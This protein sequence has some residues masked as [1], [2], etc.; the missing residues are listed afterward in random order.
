[1]EPTAPLV[2]TPANPRPP[3]PPSVGSSTARVA[4]FNIENF[5]V[6]TPSAG[7]GADNP[8]EFI[9]QRDKIVAALAGLNA[10]VIALIE[11]E[12]A[13]GNMAAANLAAALTAT[14]GVGAYAAIPDLAT[15]V[16]TDPDIKSG[17][18]YRTSSVTPVGP[19]M[20]DLA[21]AP[22]AYSRDPLTQ[23]FTVN[24]NGGRFILV[25]NHLR[26]KS[27]AG[28][29]G[30]DLDQGDGQ[31]CAN[32]RRRSQAIALVSYLSSLTLIDS[33][34]LM[35][36]DFNSYG[37]EDPLDTLRAGGLIDEVG[38][39]VP[40][41]EQYSFSFDGQ[42]GRLDHVFS[43]SHLSSQI[44]GVAFWHINADEPDIIDY[45]TENKPDD[46]YAPDAYRCADHDPLVIGLNLAAEAVAPTITCPANIS[47]NNDP[48]LCSASVAF[49]VTGTGTPSPTIVC[50]V[51]AA[52]ITSPNTFPVGT[53]TVNCTA[54]NG[55]PPN[56]TC[57]FTVTVLDTQAPT[58]TCPANITV[59]NT[60]GQCSAVVSFSVT[61]TDLCGPATI[62]STPASGSTFPK[63]TTTVTSVA[64]DGSGNTSTCSFTVTVNDTQAPVITCPANV[65]AA[66][67]S[68]QCSA[69]VNFAAPTAT[70]NCSGVGTPVCA[71]ASGSSFPKGT[72]T[73]TCSVS[74]ASSNSASCSFTV[75][76]NDTQPPSITCPANIVT[77]N[78]TGQCSAV[79]SFPAPVVSDNCSGVGTPTCSPSSGST[80]PK[81]TTT[82][83]CSV[84][85]ASG[86]ASN[87]SFTV[88]V[89][90][91]QPPSISCPANITVPCALGQ[92]S[93]LATFSVT[94]TDNCP[95]VTVVA[96]PPSGSSFPKGTTTVTATATDG[97]GNTASCSFTVTVV[98][99]QKP[100]I[101]CPA[102]ITAVVP[103]ATDT[104]ATVS[105]APPVATDNCPGVAVACTPPSGTCF[106]LGITTVTCVATDSSGNTAACSFTVTVFDACLQDDGDPSR[107]VLVN[108]LTGDYRF[109]CGG[110]MYAG[111]G[112]VSSRAGVVTLEHTGSGRRVTIRVDKML[113]VGTASLQA[114]PGSVVCTIRDTNTANNQCACQ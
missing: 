73:V 92:C 7:R 103:G 104:C 27:C 21:A 58:I 68:G 9:R 61:A 39:Y 35:V 79:V 5:F 84:A 71:P 65:T 6:T 85:D 106:P 2:F 100:S 86:N 94:A 74:D 11:L 63:G 67:D 24:S 102:N 36:G 42:L 46:R 90:D 99:T 30:L 53:T 26:S 78:T 88:T 8:A 50:K 59:S 96:N 72:T 55:N 41:S 34:V 95:G 114:P 91:T 52:T 113:K 66:N 37:Q 56:A 4:S 93:A 49:S 16:G 107:V 47:V 48:G 60:T 80:F 40:P 105:Y 18:I 23:T 20:T 54:S 10:D 112:T 89:N 38:N 17:I 45:N 1:L 31:S 82:V 76:V 108:S 83:T 19:P 101:V 77:G 81:G 14:G 44:T 51:G 33:D 109:C 75:T 70:D 64:T 12:K 87:C 110:T 15:L 111:R 97:S 28:E 22:G 98:D 29:S 32:A 57:S 62:V 69:V 13:G 25:V 3:S 43:T